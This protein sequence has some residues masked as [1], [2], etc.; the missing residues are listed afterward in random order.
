[1][2]SSP[3]NDLIFR[4]IMD[5]GANRAH[6]I[7]GAH[8]NAGGWEGWAQVELADIFN[9]AREDSC[10]ANAPNNRCDLLLTPKVQ[11]LLY[12]TTRMLDRMRE[13]P[14]CSK[15][16]REVEK[17]LRKINSAEVKA[18]VRQGGCNVYAIALAMSNEG[19]VCM[20]DLGMERFEMPEMEG[21]TPF[22]LWWDRDVHGG[23]VDHYQ[24]ETA[25]Q[26]VGRG[27]RESRGVHNAGEAFG[28]SE[29]D[30]DEDEEG[31]DEEEED[32]EY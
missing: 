1:M 21:R 25:P 32:E 4:A 15:F 10:Y 6:Y 23:Y 20:E 8:T 2:A 12:S 13:L 24:V 18:R 30:E 11:V 28:Y 31:D 19:E 14:Q 26:D 22:K 17:D 7:V 29:E 5:W 16:Q 27:I 3:P 9:A